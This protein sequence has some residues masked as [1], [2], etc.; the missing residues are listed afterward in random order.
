MKN[1]KKISKAILLSAVFFGFLA[2]NIEAKFISTIDKSSKI[3]MEEY[4]YA[5]FVKNF[6]EEIISVQEEHLTHEQAQQRFVDITNQYIAVENISRFL[7]GTIYRKKNPEERTKIR[8]CVLNLL[9]T[10]LV[11]ELPHGKSTK[12]EITDVKKIGTGKLARWNVYVKYTIDNKK[13]E[14][15]F[16]VYDTKSGRKIFDAVKDNVS[17]KKIQRAD[18]DG[19][20][21]NVGENKFLNDFYKK[22]DVKY[23]P[24]NPV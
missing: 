3:T 23:Y 18:I 5:E 1:M 24:K 9:A 19:K 16:H 6:S 8:K 20:M 2:D 12:I 22:Y 17:M 15:I 7:M 4:P 11:S 13:Y 10:R 14:V 21:R